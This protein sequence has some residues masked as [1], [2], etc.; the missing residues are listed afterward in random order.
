MCLDFHKTVV[1]GGMT[2][3][4]ITGSE[5]CRVVT[6]GSK[7]DRLDSEPEAPLALLPACSL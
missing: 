6:G 1:E 5:W 4:S 2:G 7:A 3:S